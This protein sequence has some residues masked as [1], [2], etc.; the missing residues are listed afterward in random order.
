M[1]KHVLSA[2]SK[3]EIE[4]APSNQFP[5]E[6]PT[7]LFVIRREADLSGRAVEGSAVLLAHPS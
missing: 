5:L 7:F 6:T 2:I 4:G 1:T 3:G